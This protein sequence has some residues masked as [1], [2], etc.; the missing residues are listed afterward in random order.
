MSFDAIAAIG[1]DAMLT[2]SATLNATHFVFVRRELRASGP[3]RRAAAAVLVL[4]NAGLAVQA[5]YLLGLSLADAVGHDVGA[6]IGGVAAFVRAPALAGSLALT[7][8]IARERLH[9]RRG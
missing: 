7:A 1:A 4:L 9:T 2:T 8:F 3:G 6:Y 5:S